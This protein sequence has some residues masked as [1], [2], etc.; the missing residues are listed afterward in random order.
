MDD[1]KLQELF[2]RPISEVFDITNYEN[3]LDAINDIYSGKLKPK[4]EH[5]I[6]DEDKTNYVKMALNLAGEQV[7][8]KKAE[9]IWRIYERVILKLNNF[10]LNDVSEIKNQVDKNYFI[11]KKKWDS[12]E[13]NWDNH[14]TNK[15]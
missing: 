13:K 3:I 15:K 10:S 12:E 11:N 5:K 7:D 2:G 6:S 1:K 4:E 14:L 9:F 8:S